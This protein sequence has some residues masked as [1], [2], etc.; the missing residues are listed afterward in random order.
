M[1][2]S[3][4]LVELEEIL[5]QAGDSGHQ[6]RLYLF[7]HFSELLQ[8]LTSNLDAGHL[9]AA[10]PLE[11]SPIEP[12]L[13]SAEQSVVPERPVV[14]SEYGDESTLHQVR[15][16]ALEVFDTR[17]FD[18][19]EY[20]VLWIDGCMLWGRPI[21][22]CMAATLE[23]YRHVL[24]FVEA[25]AQDLAS[26]RG[27]FQDLLDRGLSLEAGVLCIT[28]GATGLDRILTEQFGAQMRLQH[29]QMHKRTRVISHLA[30]PEQARIRGAITRAFAIPDLAF[31]RAALLEI[32]AQLAPCNRSAA[33]WLLRDLD[34]SLTVHQSGIYD[35]LSRSLRSTQCVVRAVQQLNRRLRG[36]RHWLAP[37]ARRAQF[38]LLL[39]EMEVR[40]RRLAHASYL[41][42]MRTALFA[43][44]S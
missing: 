21:L 24:G 3:E 15:M 8:Q 6:L 20:V 38:A 36:V 14:L 28:P 25:S 31:A 12:G 5:S 9:D 44:P 23:G 43:D 11:D 2:Y 4:T 1:I 17:R 34:L 18:H 41:C 40:M 26:V 27:F 33:Q 7:R 30:A 10:S 13:D 29:C 42:P 19:E 22:V 32:H 37:T 35:Q 16:D 39:L